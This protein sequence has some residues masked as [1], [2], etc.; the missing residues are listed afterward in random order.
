MAAVAGGLR[1]SPPA[2]SAAVATKLV[3]LWSKLNPVA[4]E[5]IPSSAAVLSLSRKALSE[6]AP[7]FDYNSIGS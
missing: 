3:D 5:F 4:K 1:L 2:D 7:V 6:D